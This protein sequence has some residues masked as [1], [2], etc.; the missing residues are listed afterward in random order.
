MDLSDVVAARSVLDGVIEVTP[1]LHSRWLTTRVGT[2]VYLK[3]ENLQRAGSF[4]IRGAYNRMV[5]L[6]S[7]ELARGVRS[8][9]APVS[10]R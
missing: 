10:G 6:S 7:E 4:K 1:S 5:Q 8:A 2:P 3:C 9:L